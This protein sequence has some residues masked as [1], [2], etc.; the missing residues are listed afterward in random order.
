VTVSTLAGLVL[1]ALAVLAVYIGWRQSRGAW[2]WLS[3]ILLTGSVAVFSTGSVGWEYG[4]TYAL[5]VPALLVWLAIAKEQNAKPAKPAPASPRPVSF[6]P[7]TVLFH[8]GMALAVL[9]LELIF[10]VLITLSVSRILPIEYAG[11]LAL[12][13]ILTPM[14]WG[15]L[16]YHLL[17]RPNRLKS[18]LQQTA[19]A[20]SGGLLLVVS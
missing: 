14:I 12:T 5:F 2:V 7:K 1:N 18:L 9:A 6:A 11:Q 20:V 3:L 19:I 10:S 15:L 13:V 8:M 4:L 16:S 17:G